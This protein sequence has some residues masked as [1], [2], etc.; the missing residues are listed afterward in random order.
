MSIEMIVGALGMIVSA[1]VGSI[2]SAKYTHKFQAELLLR[3]LEAQKELLQEQKKFQEELLQK[4][5]DHAMNLE[6]RREQMA[7]I[8]KISDRTYQ[9]SQQQNKK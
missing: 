7:R 4:Q 9:Q 2:L 3:Q 1:V 6:Q 5:L 8:E